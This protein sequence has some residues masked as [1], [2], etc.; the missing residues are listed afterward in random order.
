MIT[1]TSVSDK[2]LF[3][4]GEFDCLIKG[5][6]KCS[7]NENLRSGKVQNDGMFIGQFGMSRNSAKYL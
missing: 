6:L 4:N 1:I 5:L 3:I 2:F 7:I